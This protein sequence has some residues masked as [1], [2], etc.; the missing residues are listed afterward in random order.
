MNQVLT[1]LGRYVIFD[2]TEF[3]PGRL[4]PQDFCDEANTRGPFFFQPSDW[5]LDNYWGGSA[6]AYLVGKD[7]CWPMMYS[8]GFPTM[9]AALEAAT[10]WEVKQ[11][12]REK[13]WSELQEVMRDP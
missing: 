2:I 1:P 5:G 6:I 4:I 12:A 10:D 3:L 11:P 13:H 7:K 9:E 8:I